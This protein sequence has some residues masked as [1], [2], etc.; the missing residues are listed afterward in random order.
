MKNILQ[1]T[2]L[3]AQKTRDKRILELVKIFLDNSNMT[4]KELFK[5]TGI[6]TSS[7]QRYMTSSRMRELLGH[8][9]FEYIQDKRK[10]NKIE[11]LSKG[12]KKSIELYGYSKDGVGKFISNENILSLDYDFEQNILKKIKF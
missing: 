7:I 5:I 3:E 8:D 2:S 1:G 6:P 12:G 9:I 10:D 4:D 11:G